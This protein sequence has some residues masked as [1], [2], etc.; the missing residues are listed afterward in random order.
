MNTEFKNTMVLT[1]LS[2]FI[3]F[4]VF[5]MEEDAK[6]DNEITGRVT[7][8]FSDY[9]KRIEDLEKQIK[10]LEEEKVSLKRA[11]AKSKRATEKTDELLRYVVEEATPL[12]L[13]Y[14]QA[15]AKDESQEEK[16]ERLKTQAI[17]GETVKDI[18][19][20]SDKQIRSETV[21][22]I[23][24]ILHLHG[25]RVQVEASEFSS[26]EYANVTI[27]ATPKERLLSSADGLKESR[28]RASK[29]K[30]KVERMR[31]S[32]LTKMQDNNLQDFLKKYYAPGEKE[33]EKKIYK[34]KEFSTGEHKFPEDMKEAINLLSPDEVRAVFKEE[35]LSLK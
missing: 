31:S 12:A 26:V 23:N 22:S 29:K 19:T 1:L 15:T 7:K 30:E 27:K 2:L 16:L 4:P 6:E 33:V 24:R 34:G 18:I 5:A 21:N 9:R 35:N 13:L 10:S 11:K 20:Y 3:S 14:F 17:N 28:S 32:L 8:K 25:D